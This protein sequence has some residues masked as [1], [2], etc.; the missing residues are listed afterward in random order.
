MRDSFVFYRS[1][2]DA[3][4]TL[5]KRDQAAV[6]MAICEYA[7]DEKE[8]DVSGV[9]LAMFTIVKPIIEANNHRYENGKKGGRPKKPKDNQWFLDEETK[10]KPNHN[11]TKT[12]VKPN[13]N[14]NVNVNDNVNENVSVNGNE[15]DNYWDRYID[16]MDGE[17]F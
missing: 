17:D 12:K 8:P 15:N 1:F 6:F 5:N 4:R 13:V 16:D 10:P 2:Y 11:Q 9:P 3:I 7:L 14:V